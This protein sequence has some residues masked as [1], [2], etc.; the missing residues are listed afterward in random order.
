MDR[1]FRKKLKEK[2][3]KRKKII[4]KKKNTR[5]ARKYVSI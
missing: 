5:R 1:N 3:A 2:R 4:N